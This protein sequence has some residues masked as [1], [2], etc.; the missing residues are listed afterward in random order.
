MSATPP[1]PGFRNA[2]TEPSITPLHPKTSSVPLDGRI[3]KAAT[4]DVELAA[5]L[6]GAT[7]FEVAHW[8]SKDLQETVE[9]TLIPITG[10]EETDIAAWL[11]QIISSFTPPAA[12]SNSSQSRLE[13]WTGPRLTRS[14]SKV[15]DSK[16]S[17]CFMV[18][19]SLAC[20]EFH[21]HIFNRSGVIHS[22][23]HSLH[24]AADLFTRVI[25]TLTFGSPDILGFNPTFVDPTLSPSILYCPHST[26]TLQMSRA[27]Y[28]RETAY[29]VLRHIYVSH[30]IRGRGTSS[31]LVKKGKKLYIIKDYWMHKG[32]KHTE[33]QILV[34][35]KG[36][37]GVSQPK[38]P[39]ERPI[40]SGLHFWLEIWSLRLI[41]IDA[42][43][44]HP[45]AILLSNST[46][47]KNCINNILMFICATRWT[48]ASHDQEERENGTIPFMAIDLL[49]EYNS[50]SKDFMHTFSHD[51]ESLIYVLVWICVLYQA[52]N[53]IHSDWTIEQTCLKQWALAKTT[54]DIQALCDQKVGQLSTRSV[55]SDFTPYFEL[56]KPTIT[57]LYKLIQSS[58]DSGDKSILNHAAIT[59]VLMDAFNTVTEVSCGM[60]NAKQTWQ[61]L[62]KEP[63]PTGSQYYSEGPNAC[64]KVM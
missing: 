18:A 42:F 26:P 50:P 28:V 9:G 1:P 41:F 53:E 49:Q 14:V 47:C 54:A 62:Q 52:P 32:R 48:A 51:L 19:L 10:S 4:I 3:F 37:L 11:N 35:I 57:R 58:H 56:L 27:I 33:E 15:A 29:T 30:L 39:M 44:Y 31:W 64:H 17:R 40:G 7:I 2:I 34:K 21:L 46:L 61:R 60:T 6:E 59:E 38:E 5:K 63:A 16:P 55:L 45:S 25:Y 13:G 8:R 23:G 20:Q 43:C 24:R 22:L 36:L 12:E